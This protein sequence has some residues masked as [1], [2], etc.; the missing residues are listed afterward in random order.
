MTEVTFK[1]CGMCI[2]NSDH[3]SKHFLSIIAQDNHR[4][5]EENYERKKNDPANSILDQKKDR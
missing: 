2:D 1:P 3:S 5:K 4:G